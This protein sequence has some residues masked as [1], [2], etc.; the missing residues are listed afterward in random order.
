MN[1]KIKNL[2]KIIIIATLFFIVSAFFAFATTN[3]DSF[4]AYAW[5]SVI[6]WIDFYSTGNVFVYSDR[7]TGYAASSAGYIALNCDSTP[8]GNICGG[9]SGNW[10]VSNDGDGNLSG[11]AYN[12]KIGWISFSC[13]NEVASST[14]CVNYPHY[15]VILSNGDFSGYAWNDRIGWISFNCNDF[16]AGGCLV[17]YRVKTVWTA[18]P[19]E[20]NLISSIYDTEAT[21]G[22][23][24]NNIMW[25]GEQP[26]GTAVKF[27]IASS[28]NL[29]G[30]WEFKGPDG[31]S[32]TYYDPVNVGNPIQINL[33]HHNNQRY[34]R[35]KIYL[36]T[37]STQTKTPQVDNVIINW[38]P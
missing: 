18:V 7:L 19:I 36:Y 24:I 4:Y 38:S 8:N 21:G 1:F 25:H 32:A 10:K 34:F 28:N 13:Q 23:A 22:V 27:Q 5:N 17:D 12:D 30:P 6:G 15:Q 29:N 14:I 35:Y 2:N 33:A 3:I 31:S 16:G 9:F 11:W 20:G 26:I 37:D